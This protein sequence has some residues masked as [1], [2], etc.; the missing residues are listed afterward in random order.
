MRLFAGTLAA[1]VLG[2]APHVLHH[3]GPL[4]G[5]ALVAGVAGQLLFGALAFLL[6]VPMLRRMRRRTGS[7][8]VPTVALGIMAAVFVLSTLV[9]GPALTDDDGGSSGGGDAPA[10]RDHDLHHR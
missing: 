9:V 8:R 5:A 10:G 7:W 1:G 6:A 2:A 4:A 3:V